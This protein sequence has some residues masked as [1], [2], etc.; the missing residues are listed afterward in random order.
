MLLALP[1][2]TG[3]RGAL[4]TAVPQGPHL[5][6]MTVNLRDIEK[7]AQGHTAVSAVLGLLVVSRTP[8]H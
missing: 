7:L 3:R 2:G 4:L 6:R 1:R 5:Q 8:F